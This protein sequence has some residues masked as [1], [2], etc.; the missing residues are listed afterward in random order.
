MTG[1]VH[2]SLLAGDL[3]ILMYTVGVTRDT[4]DSVYV[5]LFERVCDRWLAFGPTDLMQFPFLF[6]QVKAEWRSEL[7]SAEFPSILSRQ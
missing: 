6:T 3:D 4:F 1:F 7:K 5:E 2:E